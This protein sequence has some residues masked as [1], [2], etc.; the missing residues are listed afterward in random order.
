MTIKIVQMA[1]L[2]MAEVTPPQSNGL[3][4]RSPKPMQMRE[5]F[6]ALKAIGCDP[7]EI[8][9][10]IEKAAHQAQVKYAQS[11]SPRVRAVLSGE[12]K[13]PE[14]EPFIEAWLAMALF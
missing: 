4:W 14:Q 10:A 2:F 5:L 8:G 6:A 1:G 7:K 9:E 13:V 11:V 12:S 3:H